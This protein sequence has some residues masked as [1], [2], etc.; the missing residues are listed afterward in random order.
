MHSCNRYR[1]RGGN[2]DAEFDE[3]ILGVAR[4]TRKRIILYDPAV[5]PRG[6]FIVL[7]LFIDLPEHPVSLI[8]LAVKGIAICQFDQASS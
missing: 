1:I 8:R 3:L 5:I 6:N 7:A 4:E 2:R